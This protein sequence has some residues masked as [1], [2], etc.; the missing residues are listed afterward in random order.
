MCVRVR[1]R[2]RARVCVYEGRR[3][4]RK[5][6]SII[7]LINYITDSY[8]GKDWGY[9]E[10]SQGFETCEYKNCYTTRNQSKL[11]D[12][13]AVMV[14]KNHLWQVKHKLPEKR[15]PH[16]KWF[17]RFNESPQFQMDYEPLKGR[18]NV[19]IS[20]N[21]KKADLLFGRSATNMSINFERRSV[22]N[23]TL[24]SY[25]YAAGKKNSVAWLVTNLGWVTSGR[26][27]YAR[28]LQKHIQVNIYGESVI[29]KFK[30]SG[31][32][33]TCYTMIAQS[34]KFYLSFENSICNEYVTEK[35]WYALKAN[36][37]PVVLG[38][39]DYETFLPPKSYINVKDFASPA[40]L[41]EYLHIL[42]RNDTLYNEY[43]QWRSW[44]SLREIP[45]EKCLLCEYLNR[46]K[47]MV[48]TYDKL[49][50]FWSRKDDCYDPKQFYKGK[51]DETAWV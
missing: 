23:N 40:K 51:I 7:V 6:Y 35:V 17:I 48:K 25:N 44:Y 1:V 16:Q 24:K 39:A 12:V 4:I 18:F 28:N 8:H 43:H 41:A 34:H 42:E 5:N 45:V 38:G 47:D 46:H 15:L 50:L 9:G 32:K 14:N 21:S 33:T 20:Y 27:Q 19:T 11:L 31:D 49:D 29:S 37:V 13:A 10:G 3:A 36:L 26:N 22:Q 2:A 30:C